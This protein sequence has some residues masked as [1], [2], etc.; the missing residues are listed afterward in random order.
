MSSRGNRGGYTAVQSRILRECSS[1]RRRKEKENWRHLK[2][3]FFFCRCVLCIK[4]NQGEYVLN[5]CSLLTALGSCVSSE[6]KGAKSNET[7][8]CSSA[9]AV[10]TVKTV[11]GERQVFLLWIRGLSLLY[12]SFYLFLPFFFLSPSRPSR[13]PWCLWRLPFNDYAHFDFIK[14]GFFFFL[15]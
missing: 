3:A 14:R 12:C 15:Q 7:Q 11:P 2:R 6:R 8:P 13:Q 9:F 1:Q 5:V 10:D 4:K